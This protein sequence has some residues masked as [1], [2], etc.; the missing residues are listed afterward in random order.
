MKAKT[1]DEVLSFHTQECKEA[2]AALKR[3]LQR[4]RTGRASSGLLE[5]VHADYYGTKTPITHLAQ[6]TTPEPRLIL[7]H[8]YDTKAV[9]AV[10]KAIQTSGL[11]FN[12]SRDGNSLRVVVPQLTEESRK[13]IVRHLHKIA[14]D[15]R[16]SIRNH[17]RDANELLK[18]LEKDGAIT[19]D[20]LKRLSEK[21]QKQTDG[22]I[23]E[24]DKM[25]AVKEA[26]CLEV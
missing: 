17:R 21:V 26:E 10:E 25:L 6:I 19:K 16:V 9:T 5:G 2:L 4:V 18:G 20:D 23:Q 8:V 24:V 11:G 13:E 3:E 22:S 7:L 12:P 15:I 1:A 14:E